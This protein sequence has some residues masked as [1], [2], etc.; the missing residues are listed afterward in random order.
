M[1]RSF[2][3]SPLAPW[4]GWLCGPTAW[5]IHHQGIADSVYFDCHVGEGG[6]DVLVGGLCILMALAGGVLSWAGRD[7]P[8]EG[9]NTRN[10]WFIAAVGLG[11]GLLFTVAL[12]F[13][14][15]ASLII[16]G[17]AR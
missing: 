10:R 5:V 17:C 11:M 7:G 15:L 1:A 3:T 4:M 9:V 12:S 14:T 2:L 8:E 13:Q 6:V 16:P